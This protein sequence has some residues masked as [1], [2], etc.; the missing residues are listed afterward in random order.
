MTYIATKPC[1][2]R[3]R[4][5]TVGETIPEGYVLPEA[6]DRLVK[7]GLIVNAEK[8][9][10]KETVVKVEKE[11]VETVKIVIHAVEGDLDL[12]VSPK[13]L[14][15]IF[16]VLGEKVSAA[17]SV[18]KGIDEGDALI[19]LDHAE[20]RKTVK[21]LARARAMEISGHDDASV[22]GQ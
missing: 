18:I 21:E 1:S 12:L 20:T 22:G 14:Q 5:F 2:F 16:D 9:E 17:E 7:M 13:S 15:A 10:N 11:T 19:L 8:N 6:A 4:P 3:G